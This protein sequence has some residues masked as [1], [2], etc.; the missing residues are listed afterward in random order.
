[1]GRK[2]AGGDKQDRSPVRSTQVTKMKEKNRE[3]EGDVYTTH[4]LYE[5]MMPSQTLSRS[6]LVLARIRS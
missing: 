1:M 3:S 6:S 4:S 5:I 2:E